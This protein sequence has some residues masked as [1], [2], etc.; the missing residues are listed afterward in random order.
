MS[1]PATR[2]P[3]PAAGHAPTNGAHHAST[4]SAEKTANKV[5]PQ[6]M[7]DSEF[8]AVPDRLKQELGRLINAPS[9]EIVLGNSTSYGI[10]LL[11]NGIPWNDGDEILLVE[12]DFPATIL[13]WLGL[14]G[15]GVTAR[16]V[17]PSGSVLHPEEIEARFTQKTRLFCAGRRRQPHPR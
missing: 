12:G 13:P 9:E 15:R 1:A 11:A 17:K 2:A 14:T 6:R 3:Q 7:P 4:H 10:H 5:A 16:F 8:D